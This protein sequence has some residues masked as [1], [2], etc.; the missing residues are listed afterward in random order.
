MSDGNYMRGRKRRG[1]PDRDTFAND[2]E[3]FARERVVELQA[4]IA[5]LK[6]YVLELENENARLKCGGQ[7]DG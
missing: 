3:R 1:R 6:L 7:R 4:E 5:S 2:R